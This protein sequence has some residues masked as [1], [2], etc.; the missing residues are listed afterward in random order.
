V[1]GDLR[2][3]DVTVIKDHATQRSRTSR[4]RPTYDG[5]ANALPDS[6]ILKTGLPEREASEWANGQKEVGFYRDVAP[7]LPAGLVPR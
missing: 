7:V 5:P 3:Q 1:L 6:L 4:F 2:V